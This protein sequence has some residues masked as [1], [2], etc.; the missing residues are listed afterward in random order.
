MENG[1]EFD[2]GFAPI[3]FVRPSLTPRSFLSRTSFFHARTHARIHPPTR[4]RSPGLH[5]ALFRSL[6]FRLNKWADVFGMV[7]K[8]ADKRGARER[9]RESHPHSPSRS[10]VADTR[11]SASSQAK[12]VA[13]R[14][15]GCFLRERSAKRDERNRRRVNERETSE[16]ASERSHSSAMARGVGAAERQWWG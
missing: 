4:C 8:P 13:L 7:R 14:V 11:T 15:R 1:P 6:S 12:T 9:E 10:L 5:P 16:R 3:L 2:R